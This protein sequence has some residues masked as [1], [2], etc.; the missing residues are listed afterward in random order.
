MSTKECDTFSHKSLFNM[1]S[2]CRGATGGFVFAGATQ[3]RPT[4]VAIKVHAAHAQIAIPLLEELIKVARP[5]THISAQPKLRLRGLQLPPVSPPLAPIRQNQ[6]NNP[7][8]SFFLPPPPQFPPL[9]PPLNRAPPLQSHVRSVAIAGESSL[10]SSLTTLTTSMTKLNE[11]MRVGFIEMKSM[12]TIV[13]SLTDQLNEEREEKKKLRAEIVSLADTVNT[14]T[15]KVTQ[16]EF[17]NSRPALPPPP[18][19]PPP[20]SNQITELKDILS[21]HLQQLTS[22]LIMNSSAS[23]ATPKRKKSFSEQHT[24]ESNKQRRVDRDRDTAHFNQLIRDADVLTSPHV[25]SL[26][27]IPDPPSIQNPVAPLVPWDQESAQ[28]LSHRLE[29]LNKSDS[30]DY[31]IDQSIL[32]E[33]SKRA[34]DPSLIIPPPTIDVDASQ[35]PGPM[36][37]DP[38]TVTVDPS[39][40]SYHR[41]WNPAPARFSQVSH[42]SGNTRSKAP[43]PHPTPQPT[44][45]PSPFRLATELVE[46]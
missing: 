18:P 8:P 41:V 46:Q 5:T 24:D 11:D 3:V 28:D 34:G 4:S 22:V 7:H 15:N 29:G 26:V 23:A 17:N 36:T 31:P 44:P 6:W 9:Q 21:T 27:A 1:I 37:Q 40:A 13:H 45:L 19:P 25:D 2:S 35:T 16:I 43:A 20:P 33:A 12:T 30:F 39:E 10:C 32:D 38:D 14:L 42:V